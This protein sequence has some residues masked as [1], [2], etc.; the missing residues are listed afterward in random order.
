MLEKVIHDHRRRRHVGGRQTGKEAD[1]H[2]RDFLEVLLAVNESN[3]EAGIQL[4][5]IEIKAIILVRTCPS[6]L[7]DY[8]PIERE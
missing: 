4:D 3:E 7:V 8:V 2:H 1:D 6:L 5:T